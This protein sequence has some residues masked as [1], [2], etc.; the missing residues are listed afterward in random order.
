M[1]KLNFDI[2]PFGERAVRLYNDSHLEGSSG[3]STS[4]NNSR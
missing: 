1:N 3:E 4:C 2:E